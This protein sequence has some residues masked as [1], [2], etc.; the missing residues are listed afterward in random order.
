ML[1][2]G[3]TL[4]KTSIEFYGTTKRTFVPAKDHAHNGSL[5]SRLQSFVVFSTPILCRP[6]FYILASHQFFLLSR[7]PIA[8]KRKG[9]SYGYHSNQH[10]HI[11]IAEHHQPHIGNAKRHTDT[12]V[13]RQ[14]DQRR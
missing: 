8:A 6:G 3:Q 13:H 4:A 2:V 1:G 10:K 14:E 12:H 7:E 11:D 9:Q 5:A